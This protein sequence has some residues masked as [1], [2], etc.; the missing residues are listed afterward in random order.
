MVR[1]E[2]AIA[3]RFRVYTSAFLEHCPIMARFLPASVFVLCG[4]LGTP[5]FASASIITY[6]DG[7]CVAYLDDSPLD[8]LRWEGPDGFSVTA[9]MH[10]WIERLDDSFRSPG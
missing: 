9:D 4:F 1:Y 7:I 5:L 2:F 3:A 6:D 8:C 10:T